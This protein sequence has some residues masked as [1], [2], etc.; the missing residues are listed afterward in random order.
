MP[1]WLTTPGSIL[2]LQQNRN[3]KQN[4]LLEEADLIDNPDYAFVLFKDGRES[5]IAP[6]GNLDMLNNS[7]FNDLTKIQT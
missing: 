4:S 3:T 1:S 5:N 6:S 2:I 7:S